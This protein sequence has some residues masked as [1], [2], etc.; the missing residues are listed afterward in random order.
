[1]YYLIY[2]TSIPPLMQIFLLPLTTTLSQHTHT[3][4]HT[5]TTQ[6]EKAAAST[7]RH[8]ES[9]GLVQDIVSR[10]LSEGTHL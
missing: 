1:M 4:T 9:R 6:E 10:C 5:E 8:S 2:H 3:H 7:E